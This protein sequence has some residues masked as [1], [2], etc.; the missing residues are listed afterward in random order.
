MLY[1]A[2]KIIGQPAIRIF[3]KRVDIDDPSFLREKGPLLLAANHPN[4]F[5]DAI[6]LDL[7]FEMPIYSLARGDAFYSPSVTRIL[8]ALKILPVYRTSEGVENLSD[9]YK[10]FDSCLDL[11]RKNGV[12]LMFSEGKCI[13]E[14]H[15]RPLKKG[16]ARLA[17]K[18]WEEGIPLKVLPVALNYD[19]F[20]KLG[21][22]VIIRFGKMIHKEDIPFDQPDGQ[23]NN[24][25]N[26]LL[27]A[28]LEKGVFEIDKQDEEKRA[29]LFQSKSQV[30]KKI[31]LAVPALLGWLTHAPL[32]LPLRAWARKKYLRSD[33]YDSVMMG[34]LLL[35]YPVYLI[36]FTLV[37]SLLLPIGLGALGCFLL[38]PL[39]AWCYVQV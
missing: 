11:F 25:F 27:R 18:A 32:Y 24:A 26:Q 10:T 21:K 37:V 8:T 6:I 36:L 3:C 35:A 28:E 1:S 39:L 7:Y 22:T 31:A 29:A 19:S 4:S 23:R 13:N 14:W 17:I 34:L 30:W 16:T 9:N 12:V 33:H 5:L 15:L 20:D 2:L 38:L